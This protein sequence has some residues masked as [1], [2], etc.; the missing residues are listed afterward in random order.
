MT[1]LSIQ[2]L[3]TAAEQL[4]KMKNQPLSHGKT[5]PPGENGQVFD[6]RETTAL[7][8]NLQPALIEFTVDLKLKD[9]NN[10]NNNNLFIHTIQVQTKMKKKRK[11]LEYEKL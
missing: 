10:D 9:N 2:R 7:A 3:R 5:Y 1:Q 8:F 11:R 6:N 4:M